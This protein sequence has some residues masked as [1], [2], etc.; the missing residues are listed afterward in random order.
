[1]SLVILW[2]VFL[3]FFKRVKQKTPLQI[4]YLHSPYDFPF[5]LLNWG[6]GCHSLGRLSTVAL[7]IA[8]VS[9]PVFISKL[10]SIYSYPVTQNINHRLHQLRFLPKRKHISTNNPLFSILRDGFLN[11]KVCRHISLI[12]TSVRSFFLNHKTTLNQLPQK[13]MLTSV[14]HQ[15]F[16]TLVSL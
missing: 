5:V 2:F 6:R 13:P 16:E 10:C 4:S 1:M 7:S 3:F 8:A 9:N 12:E 14:T 15:Q 11:N